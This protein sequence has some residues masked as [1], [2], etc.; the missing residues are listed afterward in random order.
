MVPCSTCVARV[1]VYRLRSIALAKERSH[2]RPWGAKAGK[3]SLNR[4]VGVPKMSQ[5]EGS[6][7]ELAEDPIDP[8]RQLG[9]DL[10]FERVLGNPFDH[11]LGDEDT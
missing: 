1:F 8:D 2:A 10:T 9:C 4:G 7:E 5:R 3:R 6:W 11:P